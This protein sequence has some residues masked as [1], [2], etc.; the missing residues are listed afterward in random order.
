MKKHEAVDS[1]ERAGMTINDVNARI[2]D[3]A[4]HP[5]EHGWGKS[6]A[7]IAAIPVL[8]AASIGHLVSSAVVQQVSP[9]VFDRISNLGGSKPDDSGK[10]G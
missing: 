3:V 1:L 5:T 6:L 8:S 7:S 9:D 4:L 2:W 10:S